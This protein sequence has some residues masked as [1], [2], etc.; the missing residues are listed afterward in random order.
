M[1]QPKFGKN[2][3]IISIMTLITVFIWIGYEVYHA[4]TA[5]TVP[6]VVRELIQ[7]LN[8][9]IDEAIIENIKE[10]YQIPTEELEVVTQPLPSPSP[11]GEFEEEIE[12]EA[13]TAPSQTTTPSG[14]LEGE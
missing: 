9:S 11:E 4:Y 10:K 13:E 2:I 6:T 3:L 14:S 8:P 1:D 7:P 5:T 12:I